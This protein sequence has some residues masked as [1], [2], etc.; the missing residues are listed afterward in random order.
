[1]GEEK[2][3]TSKCLPFFLPTEGLFLLGT[4]DIQLKKQTKIKA[5][6]WNPMEKYDNNIFIDIPNPNI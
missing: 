5:W 1:M 2:N 6:V 4:C 3:K